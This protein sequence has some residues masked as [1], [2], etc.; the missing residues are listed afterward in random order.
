MSSQ[1][2]KVQR[3][4]LLR[5]RD[6]A[7]RPGFT[8][9]EPRERRTARALER[10]GLLEFTRDLGLLSPNRQYKITQEGLDAL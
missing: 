6:N 9:V 8:M 10:A 5:A 3:V 2:T 1:L 7:W 4:M